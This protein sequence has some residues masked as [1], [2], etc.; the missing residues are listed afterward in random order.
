[1]DNV[2]KLKALPFYPHIS[3]MMKFCLQAEV[4]V[5]QSRYVVFF[6]D[7]AASTNSYAAHS[8]E[9]MSWYDTNEREMHF[10]FGLQIMMLIKQQPEYRDYWSQDR[11][12][13][14]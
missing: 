9:G 13:L 7:M 6:A 11:H 3:A 8:G 2:V 12:S 5:L 10:F 14:E 1:M 4:D